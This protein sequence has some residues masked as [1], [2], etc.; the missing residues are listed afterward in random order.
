MKKPPGVGGKCIRKINV[1]C[2]A[3]KVIREDDGCDMQDYHGMLN[4]MCNYTYY[5]PTIF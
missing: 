2:V 3:L 4:G 5:L 1:E